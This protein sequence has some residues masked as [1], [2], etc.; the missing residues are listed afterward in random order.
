MESD[1]KILE[2]VKI[3]DLL[4]NLINAKTIG[5]TDFHLIISRMNYEIETL[6]VQ[7]STPHDE[8]MV[9]VKNNDT[10]KYY[11]VRV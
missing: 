6:I 5:I 9:R 8:G 3:K 1:M 7:T 11:I 10:G 2:Y 4:D